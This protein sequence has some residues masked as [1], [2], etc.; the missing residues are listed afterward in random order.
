MVR[1]MQSYRALVATLA[2]L[3]L[4]RSATVLGETFPCYDAFV[5]QINATRCHTAM[6][7]VGVGDQGPRK[8]TDSA[9]TIILLY[10]GAVRIVED[11]CFDCLSSLVSETKETRTADKIVT[12]H[13]PF[14]SL[15]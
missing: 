11:P 2:A 7:S 14:P 9:T 8:A 6:L 3:V 4:G 13:T 15:T 10:R 1:R 5:Q 12:L